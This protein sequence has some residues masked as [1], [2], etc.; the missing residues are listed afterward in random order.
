[1][2]SISVFYALGFHNAEPDFLSNGNSKY[3]TTQQT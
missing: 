3:Q 1:M 2:D